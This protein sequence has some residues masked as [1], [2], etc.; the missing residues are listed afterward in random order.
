MPP[1][2]LAWGLLPCWALASVVGC[3]SPVEL[4]KTPC[5]C[6]EGFSCCETLGVCQRP[7][8]W[9]C[10]GS[11]PRSSATA[12]T[13]DEQC[14]RGE[15]CHAWSDGSGDATELLGPRRC[16]R[17]CAAG[18]N[19]TEPEVCQLALHDGSPVSEYRVTSLCVPSGSS[20]PAG[21]GGAG[22]S[23][24]GG[25]DGGAGDDCAQWSCQGCPLDKIGRAYCLGNHMYGCLVSTS[26]RCGLLCEKVKVKECITCT[27]SGA[28]VICKQ[29]GI[30]PHDPCHEHPCSKC[31]VSKQTTFCSVGAVSTCMRMAVSHSSCNEACFV[32]KL[33]PCPKSCR[34]EGSEASCSGS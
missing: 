32:K 7:G 10:P 31:P 24:L 16:R 12:C 25:G 30:L 28:S 5:P 26:P 13:R 21:D 1:R 17:R 33:T 23:D 20:G 22:D 19:C 8:Q 18:T 34:Q 2:I 4:D 6:G 11:Y 14:P 29:L 27:E 9:S 3:V 15:A